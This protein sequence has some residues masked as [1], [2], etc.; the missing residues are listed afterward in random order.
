MVAMM[1]LAGKPAV[2]GPYTVRRKTR[3]LGW[4]AVVVMAAAVAMMFW[5]ALR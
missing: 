3:A 4:G 2:M 1:L 5:D